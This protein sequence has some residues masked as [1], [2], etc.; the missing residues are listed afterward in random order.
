MYVDF[1]DRSEDATDWLITSWLYVF[2]HHPDP[3]VVVD[4]LRQ[5]QIGGS[6]LTVVTVA[7][8][9]MFHPHGG[10]R[11]EAVRAVW[12]CDDEAVRRVVNVLREE[13]QGK[14]SAKSPY[15]RDAAARV[16]AGRPHDRFDVQDG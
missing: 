1:V 13:V 11:E 10:V 15:V 12:R 2:L 3:S 16:F 8:L 9:L 5:P 6:T 4:A 14:A 7:D